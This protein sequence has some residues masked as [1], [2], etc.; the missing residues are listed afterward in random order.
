MLN[1]EKVPEELS[2]GVVP[3]GILSWSQ[4][5]ILTAACSLA[6]SLGSLGLRKMGKGAFISGCQMCV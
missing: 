1:A 5:G 3:L 2:L 4:S 6:S